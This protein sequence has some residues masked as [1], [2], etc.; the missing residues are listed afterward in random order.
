MRNIFLVEYGGLKYSWADDHR[1]YVVDTDMKR[2]TLPATELPFPVFQMFQ[3]KID[4]MKRRE[5]VREI[6][7]WRSDWAD[8]RRGD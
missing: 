1:F 7:E 3:A 5:E 8:V 4:D 6:K 2:Y